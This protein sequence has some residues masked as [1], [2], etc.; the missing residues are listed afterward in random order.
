V[1]CA[2]WGTRKSNADVSPGVKTIKYATLLDCLH[3]PLFN[4]DCTTW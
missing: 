3:H 2:L 4:R 1:K